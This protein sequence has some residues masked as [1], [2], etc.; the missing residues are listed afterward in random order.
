MIEKSFLEKEKKSAGRTRDMR[1]VLSFFAVMA[2]LVVIFFMTGVS[3]FGPRSVLVSDLSAQYAPYLAT[4]RN[5][6]LSGRSLTYSFEIGMGKNFMGI[7]AYYLSSPLNLLALLF[8][9]SRISEAI[10]LLITLKISFAGAFMTAYLD[11]K[12]KD[13]S[14]MTLLFGLIYALSSFSMSFIF[15]FIWLDGFALLP[16][17][18]LATELFAEN[19]KNAWKL[20]IV[21]IVLFAS[22]YYMA[23]MAGLFSFFYLLVI[24]EYKKSA[25]PSDRSEE[26][27]RSTSPGDGKVVGVF[28]LI[29]ICAALILAILLIP[30]GLDTLRNGDSSSS[31]S[32]TLNPNFSLVKFLPQFFLGKLTDISSNMPFVYSSLLVFMLVVLL[33]RNPEVRSGL[34][35]RAGIGIGLGVLS[36]ILPPLNTAW[37]LFDSP[38]WFL[39]RYAYLFIFGTVLL[40]YY[41]FLH[42]KSLRNRDFTFSF[43]LFFLLLVLAECFGR[44][45]S[46]S[47][48]FFQN[49]LVGGLI[50]LCLWGLTKERWTPSLSDLQKWGVGILVP[51][52]LVEIVFLAPKVTVGAIWNDSQDSAA[53]CEEVES[54]RS[55][56]AS[57]DPNDPGRTEASGTLGL[58]LDSLTISS[59]SETHGISA[60]CSMSN[61][62]QQRFLKQLGYCTNYNYFSVEHRNVILPA[63]SILGIRYYVSKSDAYPTEWQRARNDLF[64]L[65]ENPYA[66]H[67]AFV[68]DAGALEFDGYA[69]EQ[70]CRSKD[71]LSFQEAWIASL[72][73]VSAENLYV[74]TDDSDWQVQNGQELSDASKKNLLKYDLKDGMKPENIEEGTKNLT[75]YVRTTSSMPI[76]LRTSLTVGKDG[77][78]YLSIPFLM[79]SAPLSVYCN[80]ELI[81]KEESTSYFSVILDTGIHSIGDE[82][83][84]EIRCD[85]D[86][87]ASFTPILAYCDLEV[88]DEQ[89]TILKKD[90]SNVNVRDGYV[91]LDADAEEDRV[92]I[93]T[94][95]YEE[96]WTAK[97]DGQKVQVVPYQDAFISIPIESGHHH[98]ELDFTPPGLL[99]GGI[100]SIAGVIASAAVLL[101]IQRSARK[102]R[103]SLSH[104]TWRRSWQIP[105]HRSRQSSEES[106][107]GRR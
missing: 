73:G 74:A 37:H 79:R 32:V 85:D 40:S 49:L 77:P 72:T 1:P 106:V 67:I 80:D 42:L 69:L 54:L 53:F 75:Y 28:I 26:P 91:A 24:L 31:F 60:F 66:V 2:A 98:V 61:K 9:V 45:Q 68:A 100:L 7:L 99:V 13:K 87:F 76:V 86:I 71:Y 22:G 47:S 104:R 83:K 35:I 19:M 12:F 15:N 44:D 18:I 52:V 39:Y 56:T 11:H 16:L 63:D 55:V 23:Y 41:S 65:W 92:L 21:L 33:F 50:T 81:Y 88:L 34:K 27:G 5:K 43:G 8:P 51:I 20:L 102:Q 48:M 94:I 89:T 70:A 17:L 3:P 96:G 4:L 107:P 6:L 97:V 105:E 58:N 59:Y 29:A 93:T 57:I 82:L 101:L 90:I 95:P 30:A 64:A 46:V 103:P 78:L 62:K 25:Q 84:I 14:R 10:L 36:F 38:N